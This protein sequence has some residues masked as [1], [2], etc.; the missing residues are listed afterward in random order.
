M[1]RKRHRNPLS[2]LLNHKNALWSN[3]KDPK[4]AQCGSMTPQ[5]LCVPAIV[6]RCFTEIMDRGLHV[7]G[8]FRLSGAASET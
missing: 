3:L 7:E 5:G 6:H 4:K 1:D 8:I 2:F